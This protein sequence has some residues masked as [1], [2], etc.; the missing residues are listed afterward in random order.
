[1]RVV[2]L[3]AIT[4]QAAADRA[5]FDWLLAA[6][7]PPRAA[8]GSASDQI[9]EQV[10]EQILESTR[11]FAE[12]FAVV[13]PEPPEWSLVVGAAGGNSGHGGHGGKGWTSK[14]AELLL[15]LQTNLFYLEPTAIGIYP[16]S[17]LYEHACRQC[18]RLEPPAARAAL[19][20]QPSPS[21]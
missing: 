21:S 19:P 3:L 7:R 8:G 12:K 18:A 5:L 6:L 2:C 14:L 11:S 17:W 1:M 16:S 15:R 10:H 9:H 20:E 4:I 13:I